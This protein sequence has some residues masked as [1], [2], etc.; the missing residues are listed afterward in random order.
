[1]A[2]AINTYN[3][4]RVIPSE[5]LATCARVGIRGPSQGQL[6]V[7]CNCLCCSLGDM[8]SD[9]WLMSGGLCCPG[10][11][12]ALSGAQ[13]HSSLSRQRKRCAKG[14]ATNVANGCS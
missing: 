8:G 11:T 4:S 13:G 3:N 5:D 6:W 9:G 14:E 10:R 1:M 7:T 2:L 12:S